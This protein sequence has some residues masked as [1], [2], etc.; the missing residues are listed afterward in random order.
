MPRPRV[1]T[2]SC[3]TTTVA[4]PSTSDSGA[5]TSASALPTVAG[6]TSA[7][8][9]A[10]PTGRPR[11]TSTAFS[12]RRPRSTQASESATEGL[13]CWARS[14]TAMGGASTQ[15]RHSRMVT[16]PACACSRPLSRSRRSTVSRSPSCV[17]LSLTSLSLTT[18]T[19]RTATRFTTWSPTT[20]PS[21]LLAAVPDL[22][23]SPSAT[24]LPPA[25]PPTG[26]LESK[27]A[28]GSTL[29]LSPSS[30]P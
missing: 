4:W 3:C 20:A 23:L 1:T 13:S 15:G 29:P 11:A 5:Q 17:A 24:M 6:T 27:R 18:S 25:N 9:G 16:L 19:V 7:R 26:C 12:S 22:C 30:R 14:R 8:P 28:C 2:S 21:V 10:P